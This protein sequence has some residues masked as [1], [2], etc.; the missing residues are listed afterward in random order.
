VLALAVSDGAG[1]ASNAHIGSLLTCEVLLAQVQ[2]LVDAGRSLSDVTEAEA[3]GWL[4]A[5]RE[6]IAMQAFEDGRAMRDYACTLLMAVVDQ[7]RSIF[8]QVG[9]GAIVTSQEQAEWSWVFWPARGEFANTTYFVTDDEA[10]ERLQVLLAP[11]RVAE[12]ALF[13]DGI[14]P[15]V[16]HYASKTVHASFFE[17]MLPPVRASAAN[18]EDA[19]LSD[20]L[21]KYLASPAVTNRTDDDKTLVLATTRDPLTAS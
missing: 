12:L 11:G 2:A 4:D 10:A 15:L 1:S 17:R 13:S 20:E 19:L 16:L 8:L 14:E 9:D 5:V 21:K 18:G 7:D 6:A 3:R